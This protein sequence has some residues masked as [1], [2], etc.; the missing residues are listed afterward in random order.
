MS[1][2]GAAEPTTLAIPSGVYGP[3]RIEA[4][5]ALD[6]TRDLYGD[7]NHAFRFFNERLFAGGLQP[8]LI[9]LRAT[10]RTYGYFAAERFVDTSTGRR[11]H[12]IAFNPE[13][14]AQRGIED[15]LSTLV[16]EQVHLLQYQ[17]GSASR[18]AYHNKDFEKKM[19]AVGLVPSS[20]GQ[21]G[22][23]S[24]GE[25]MT[26]YV[27]I[28]GPFLVAARELVDNA[29]RLRWSDRF[30]SQRFS[31]VVFAKAVPGGLN[32]RKGARAPEPPP[33]ATPAPAV[34]GP[35]RDSA[36]RR[37]RRRSSM[38]WWCCGP[39]PRP[40]RRRRPSTSARAAR[41]RRGASRRCTWSAEI[42]A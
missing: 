35:A 21:P 6:P 22:G 39:S 10:G 8:T 5:D 29:F 9:T 24:V 12:E 3:D 30:I 26:H 34:E 28:D 37:H 14:F 27:D 36:R 1:A 20:T 2:I 7:L 11:V 33:P 17:D 42:A 23:P 38:D 31:R 13:T 16:H 18:R 32:R 41:A 15:V 40:S 4:A 25:K 19:R